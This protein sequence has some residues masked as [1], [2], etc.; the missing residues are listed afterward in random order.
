MEPEISI[1]R[2]GEK[3][4]LKL[5]GNFDLASSSQLLHALKRLVLAT[6]EFSPPNSQISFTF[7]TRGKVD[8]GRARP[9]C[10][11][12]HGPGFFGLPQY[13]Q[14]IVGKKAELRVLNRYQ[15]T[16]SR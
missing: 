3:V 2:K 13:G 8:L 7:S 4:Y 12:R 14:G 10:P 1:C 9:G 11:R 16:G 5:T 6:L 15:P